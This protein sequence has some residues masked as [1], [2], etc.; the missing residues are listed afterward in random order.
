MTTQHMATIL[1]TATGAAHDYTTTARDTSLPLEDRRQAA[2]DA[3]SEWHV[4]LRLATRLKELAEQEYAT[5]TPKVQALAPDDYS[6]DAIELD[7]LW[8]NWG[9][10]A[11]D[12]DA[13]A[14][15]SAAS[16]TVEKT[17]DAEIHGL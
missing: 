3:D 1:K 14:L 4:T 13:L 12:M 7:N 10:L 5:L 17:L 9:E 2:R 8:R 16:A 6:R 15:K 11:E